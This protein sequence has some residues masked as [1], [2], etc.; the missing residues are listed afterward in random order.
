MMMVDMMIVMKMIVI[1]TMMMP[2]ISEVRFPRIRTNQDGLRTLTGHAKNAPMLI[3]GKI[4]TNTITITTT[5][6][7]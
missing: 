7:C 3:G 5:Y 6:Y 1:M 4:T 2:M